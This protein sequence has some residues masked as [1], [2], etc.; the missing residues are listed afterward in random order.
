MKGFA[1]CC[2][3]DTACDYRTVSELTV[4]AFFTRSFGYDLFLIIGDRGYGTLRYERSA[5]TVLF[6]TTPGFPFLILGIWPGQYVLAFYRRSAQRCRLAWIYLDSRVPS[7]SNRSTS[8]CCNSHYTYGFSWSSHELKPTNL[9]ALPRSLSLPIR[10]NGL[11]LDAAVLMITL[12]LDQPARERV[13][14]LPVMNRF[15]NLAARAGRFG[16]LHQGRGGLEDLEAVRASRV[17]ARVSWREKMRFK[18]EHVRK[19][20]PSRLLVSFCHGFGVEKE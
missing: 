12:R 3:I 13:H 1:S 18:G 19:S 9:R 6:I 14:C 11:V 8:C 15:A 7:G 2:P 5:E 4:C 16:M 17:P 10:V 20:F